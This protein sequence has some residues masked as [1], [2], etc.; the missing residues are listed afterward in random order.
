MFFSTYVLTKKGP[1]AKVWLAAHWDKRLT[2]NEVKV[3]DLTQTIVFIV[4]PVVPI[5][6]RTSGELLVG[7]VRIYALKVKHLLREATEATFFLRMS[8]TTTKNGSSAGAAIDAMRAGSKLEQRKNSSTRWS[9][10]WAGGGNNANHVTTHASLT[11]CSDIDAVTFGWATGGP[12]GSAA[13]PSAA[14]GAMAGRS[15]DHSAIMMLDG[16]ESVAESLC[17]ARF[18]TVADILSGGAGG[19]SDEDGIS[20]DGNYSQA[21]PSAAWY[22]MQPSAQGIHEMFSTQLQQSQADGTGV[23]DEIARIRANWLA[24]REDGTASGSATTSKSKSSMSSIENVRGSGFGEV[25]AAGVDV[26]AMMIAGA[27]AVP[28]SM[29]AGDELDIGVPLPPDDEMANTAFPLSVLGTTHISAGQSGLPLDPFDLPDMVILNEEDVENAV[30]DEA[31][32]G[33]ASAIDRARQRR[34]GRGVNVVDADSTT[35]SREVVEKTMH[36]RS[37][38]VVREVQRG[39]VDAQEV[40]DRYMLLTSHANPADWLTAQLLEDTAMMNK[41][42]LCCNSDNATNTGGVSAGLST[43]DWMRIARSTPV[44]HV[45]A[46][47]LQNAFSSAL[48][49]SLVSA[50]HTLREA[51]MVARERQVNRVAQS[52]NDVRYI[53]DDAAMGAAA[54]ATGLPEEEDD[55]WTASAAGYKRERDEVKDDVHML[56]GDAT[57]QAGLSVTATRTL[58]HIRGIVQRASKRA[59]ADNTAG[60]TCTLQTICANM[61]RRDAART[62]VDLLALTS[63]QMVNTWQEKHTSNVFVSLT[64]I[65]SAVTV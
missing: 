51:Q 43:T 26:N 16:T 15:L 2:R 11:F 14:A 18:D 8:V 64:S 54:G 21:H 36:D 20:D 23:N 55:E 22:T 37:D 27:D 25:A 53:D 58:I 39:P 63:Q 1:L 7:V 61:T 13:T 10:E 47:S 48:R 31:G 6:L 35:L 42:D 52:R 40:Q 44:S 57:N 49:S 32:T 41:R 17:E 9:G 38:I 33:A 29:M 50:V 24:A 28:Y 60:T 65:G 30:S 19:R 62:F 12:G 3:V 4:R 46:L 59:R 56:D 34:K 45:P 5:A